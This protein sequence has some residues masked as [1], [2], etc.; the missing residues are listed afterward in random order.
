MQSKNQPMWEKGTTSVVERYGLHGGKVRSLLEGM[1]NSS[2]KHFVPKR[3]IKST[4]R[5]IDW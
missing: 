1:G 2:A 4:V 3:K 5:K